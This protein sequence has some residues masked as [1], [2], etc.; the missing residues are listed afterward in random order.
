V[1]GCRAGSVG[2][3]L[4]FPRALVMPFGTCRCL[5]VVA[6]GAFGEAGRCYLFGWCRVVLL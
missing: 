6:S 5:V 3:L 1:A 2:G 4:S